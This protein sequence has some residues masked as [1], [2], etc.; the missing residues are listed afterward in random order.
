MEEFERE[1]GKDDREVKRQEREEDNREYE[2]GS[3]LGRFA[4]KKLFGWNNKR[5]DRE[6]W[7]RLERNWRK[8]KRTRP[9]RQRK[10]ES[11]K[12]EREEEYQGGRIEEWNKEDKIGQM[13]DMI[14]EL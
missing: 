7:E 3:F 11:I 8:W 9:W 2:R 4:A 1:Y 14:E 13:E 6:Y 5:Y 12:E 10:L